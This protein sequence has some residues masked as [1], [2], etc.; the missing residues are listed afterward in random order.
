MAKIPILTPRQSMQQDPFNYFNLQPFEGLDVAGSSTQI[1]D[2]ESPDMLN[3][4]SDER[5]SLNKRMGY[6][7]TYADSLGS[8][9]V[10]GLYAFT[11][12]NNAT[13]LLM[14]WGTNLYLLNGNAQ[15][16]SIYS[17]LQNTPITFFT[18]N[19]NCY[20]LDGVNFLVY[21]GVT[22]QAVVPYVPTITISSPP[23]GGGAANEDFNLIGNKFKASF[24]GD[25]ALNV[26]HM[27]LKP[28]DAT[29]VTAVVGTTTITEGSGLTVDR[30]NGVITFTT[31]P[32]N[33][34]NN[35]VITAGFTANKASQILQ[36]TQATPYGGANDTR[37]F[38]TGNPN[39]P[40]YV[41]RSGLY[42][43]EYWPENG[44]YKYPGKVMGLSKQYDSLIVHRA[45]G[46]HHVQYTVDSNTGLASFPSQPLSDEVGTKAGKS[47][48]VVENNPTFLSKDGVFMLVGTNVRDER[49]TVHTSLTI[50][51]KLLNE[52]GLENAISIVFDKRYWLAVNGNVYVLD[53]ALKS[54]VSPYGKWYI[55]NNINASC[56]VI[57]ND[58]LYF[59]SE[60]TGMVYQFYT[61]PDNNN[62]YND[63]GYPII[64]YWKT[65]PLAFGAENMY[66]MIDRL[67]IG[68]KPSG[69]TSLAVSYETNKYKQ[70]LKV[71]SFNNMNFANFTF[72][73]STMYLPKFN[74]FNFATL[75][76]TNFTF[77]YSS[78]AQ[79][80]V[81]RVKERNAQ[82]FQLKLEN[83]NNNE[84]L[85]ILSLTIKYMYS[86]YLTR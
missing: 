13:F 38:L 80:F 23:A 32:A 68:L 63:D 36:C 15:P 61:E 59:G 33:G 1:N 24:S 6:K 65:K 21:D 64:A 2:H 75:D 57:Y 20:I 82:Y 3:M 67:F 27:P 60:T 35:V 28:L 84:S 10:N 37:I 22:C 78:F 31:V 17:G 56:F 5:G 86:G 50:D 85:S 34:T 25:G 76:F 41:Y 72:R 26:Y 48:R 18:M 83:S 19:G 66:K 81:V 73:Y 47:I 40:D 52:T 70:N 8:G 14:A 62:S 69:K 54:P 44:F 7:R 29:P 55:Y 53:Y 12:N 49:D 74:L 42:Q 4:Y 45:N 11:N 58:V 77:Q 71:F 16:T 9:K 39:M 51:H 46:I 79:E 43:P 30:L